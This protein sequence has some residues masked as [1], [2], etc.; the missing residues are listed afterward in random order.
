MVINGQSTIVPIIKTDKYSS[1]SQ[2]TH[3][4]L[5][6][7]NNGIKTPHFNRSASEQNNFVNDNIKKARFYYR[8]VAFNAFC[9][10]ELLI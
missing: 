7:F 3:N 1:F 4:D 5:T 8:N 2:L 6:F 9:D 10:Y